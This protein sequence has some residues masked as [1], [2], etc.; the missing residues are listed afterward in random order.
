MLDAT[1]DGLPVAKEKPFGVSVVVWRRAG[2]GLEWLVLH[3]RHQG[4]EYEGDWAWTPPAGARLPGEATLACAERE[5]REEAGL[6]LPLVETAHRSDEWVVFT[7][8]APV[9]A[10]IRLDDE[11]DRHEW[12]ALEDAAARCLPAFVGETFRRA[13]A[14]L[15]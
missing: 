15:S 11:H 2:I 10:E 12:L 5:L 9:A 8:E 14:S 7:A 6:S 1:W 4:P 13:A 3:R